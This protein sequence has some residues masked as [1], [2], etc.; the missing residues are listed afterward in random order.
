MISERIEALRSLMKERNIDAYIIPTA[1]FHESEYVG[2]YFKCR[3]FMSGFTGSAGT[4]VVTEKKAGLWTDGRY[5]LQAEK[6]LNDSEI[7]LYRM[8]NEGV[9]GIY[10]FLLENVPENGVIGF[11]GRTVSAGQGIEYET[12][13]DI[14]SGHIFYDEDLVD[15]IWTDRPALSCK[16]VYLIDERKAGASRREKLAGLRKKMKENEAS[17]H[18]ISTLDDIAWL[19]NI[20]GDDI[21]Y[22]PVALSYVLLTEDECLL[23]VQP[24]AVSENVRRSLEADGVIVLNYDGFYEY[25]KKIKKPVLMDYERISYALIKNL[26][27]DIEKADEQNPTILMKAVKNSSEIEGMREAHIKDGVAVA[28]FMHWLKTNIGRL[29]I[30]EMSAADRLEEFRKEQPGFFEPSFETISAYASNGAIVHYSPLSDTDRRLESRGFLLVDSGGQYTNGTTD[31]TRTFV[32][33]EITKEQRMHYTAVLK[34]MLALADAKFRYGCTGHNLDYIA[35]E[36]LWRMGL[37]YNHGTGHGVGFMLNVHEAPNS[38]R[39]REAGGSAG[40]VIEPGMITSD[41]PGVYIAGSHGIR[42]ENLILCVEKEKNE[43][44]RF[45]GFEHL[46]MAPI[47][48]DGIDMDL[49]G[50][51][52]IKRLNTYHESVYN[53]LSPYMSEEDCI[54]LR[55]YTKAIK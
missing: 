13:A 45:L 25:V 7:E 31:I 1:D 22:N 42:I 28:R 17:V 52:D 3:E 49:M 23:F 16:P 39:W 50:E 33:G 54:W 15:L 47:D 29:P 36:P 43:Y 8:G 35:R 20:R 48:L 5:F 10:D 53:A 12:I 24:E 32:L 21:A 46:T 38:F 14:K 37:D 11:D 18:V 41:E 44:G 26:D 9:P 27:A 19:L 40:T 30:T 55:E 6:Q 34:G 2:D 4:L 51:M